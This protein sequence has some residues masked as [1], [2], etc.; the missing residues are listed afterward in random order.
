MSKVVLVRRFLAGE[1]EHGPTRINGSSSKQAP[2]IYFGPFDWRR[3]L[4]RTTFQED[5]EDW[6]RL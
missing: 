6:R 1:E 3:A 2:Y 5:N 4:P